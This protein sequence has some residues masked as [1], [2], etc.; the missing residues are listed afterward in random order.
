MKNTNIFRNFFHAAQVTVPKERGFAYMCVRV[1]YRSR[2]KVTS[3]QLTTSPCSTARKGFSVSRK[4]KKLVCYFDE[5]F[6]QKIVF[7]R[8]TNVPRQ[9]SSKSGATGFEI[10]VSAVF[11][12]VIFMEYTEF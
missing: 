3:L 4:K 9:S 1:L 10:M 6:F 7:F 5:F 12:T 11:M 8:Q 2:E